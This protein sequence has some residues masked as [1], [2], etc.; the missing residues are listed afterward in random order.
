MLARYE[1]SPLKEVITAANRFDLN[2]VD[3]KCLIFNAVEKKPSD[4]NYGYE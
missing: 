1:Q 2:G 4:Y 3:I